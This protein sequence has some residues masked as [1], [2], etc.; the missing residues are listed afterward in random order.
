MKNISFILGAMVI[1]AGCNPND[2]NKSKV[3]VP[4]QT[5]TPFNRGE[6]QD[7]DLQKTGRAI[8]EWVESRK[9]TDGIPKFVK[10]EILAPA[11]IVMPYGVGMFQ[12]EMRVPIILTTGMGW[13]SLQP[14][15]KEKEVIQAFEEFKKFLQQCTIPRKP[16]LTLQTPQGLEISWVNEIQKGQKL[17][18]GDE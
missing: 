10:T 15:E 7:A 14:E 11:S 13:K 2:Q 17:V 1:I 9:T 16:S 8:R 18:F 12:Q 3:I 5:Q 6:T 4:A